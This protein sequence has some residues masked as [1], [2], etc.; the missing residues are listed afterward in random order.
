M[1]HLRRAREGHLVHSGMGGYGSS[2]GGPVAAHHVQHARGEARLL[3]QRGHVQG[4][5]R[6]L[7]RRLQDDGVAG[8]Q[9][10]GQLP[11]LHQQ[12]EVPG[13]DL[14]HDPDGLQAGHAEVGPVYGDGLAVDLVR[15]AGVVAVAL[16]GEVQVDVEGV[17]IRFPVV[18]GLQASQVLSIALHQVGQLVEEVSA[19]GGVHRAPGTAQLEGLLGGRDGLVDVCLVALCDVADLVSRGRVDGGEGL[20]AHGINPFVVDEELR[21]LD[22]SHS[23]S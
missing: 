2:G 12:G 16:H 13:D 10:G 1:A 4:R 14:A 17:G 23:S 11:G 9:G 20:S 15:P 3:D 5:Q 7:L 22:I 6:G 21:E 18:E 8:A 19:L